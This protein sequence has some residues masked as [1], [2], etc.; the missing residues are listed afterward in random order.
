MDDVR[1]ATRQLEAHIVTNMQVD[2]ADAVGLALLLTGAGAMQVPEQQCITS[3]SSSSNSSSKGISTQLQDMLQQLNQ[4]ESQLQALS[5]ELRDLEA[6]AALATDTALLA[7]T[8]N[9]K[10]L[11]TA[12]LQLTAADSS[13][14]QGGGAGAYPCAPAHSIPAAAAADACSAA[15]EHLPVDT[16]VD[17]IFNSASSAAAASTATW[18]LQSIASRRAELLLRWRCL[19]E[20]RK[21]LTLLLQVE[22]GAVQLLQWST[23]SML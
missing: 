9:S 19:L 6:A 12:E 20:Q 13:S 14:K 10:Q 3:S 18:Q 1:Q 23:Q 22:Q 11:Q 15:G 8:E 16:K 7:G 21:Q 4:Q 17:S 2:S 5:D